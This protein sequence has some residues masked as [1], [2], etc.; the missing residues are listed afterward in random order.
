MRF[1]SL[2][3]A[4]AVLFCVSLAAPNAAQAGWFGTDFSDGWGRT[5]T[6]THRI[7]NPRY[8]HV[9]KSRTHSDPY[10][11]RY[12]PRRYYTKSTSRYWVP[13]RKA[14]RHRTVR[15]AHKYRYYPAWG[16]K[17]S[18]RSARRWAR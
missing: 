18:R 7:Y 16:Y 4:L 13:A 1:K 6:I 2:L 5:R 11:Y 8:R 12:V 10:A 17:K 3:A 15:S 9:Y 14:H